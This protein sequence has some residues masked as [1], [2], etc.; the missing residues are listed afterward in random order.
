M[1]LADGIYI[2]AFVQEYKSEKSLEAL[3]KL[4]PHYCH[5]IRCVYKLPP[6]TVD[7]SIY[8]SNRNGHL[9]TMLAT[10]LVPGDVVRFSTGDR[11]PADVRLVHAADL[12]LDESSLTGENEPCKKHA[13]VIESNS[14]DLPLAERKNIT[15]MGTLVRNGMVQCDADIDK[16]TWLIVGDCRAR[17]GNRHRDWE[18]YGVWNGVQHDEGGGS[19]ADTFAELDGPSGQAVVHDVVCYYW[20]HYDHW[21][22]TRAAMAGDVYDWR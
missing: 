9:T 8:V 21:S 15:F 4:V 10:E 2:V 6:Y 17:D 5:V 18:E 11:I 7:S 19:A 1:M 20:P 22:D 13:D 16:R 12:E 3:N 14:A